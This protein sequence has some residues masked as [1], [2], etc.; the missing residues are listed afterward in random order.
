MVIFADYEYYK[1]SYL[2]STTQ[3]IDENEYPFLALK[4]TQLINACTFNRVSKKSSVPEEVKMCCCE[5]VDI[6]YAEKMQL[7]AIQIDGKTAEK[8]GDYSV[9]YGVTYK[10]VADIES[11]FQ[12]KKQECINMWLSTT[13]LLYGGIPYVY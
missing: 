2:K 11:R 4:A 6:F 10:D 5:L 9:S 8:V 13:G 1:S 3:T 12:S 7:A